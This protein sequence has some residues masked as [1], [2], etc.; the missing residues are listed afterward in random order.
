MYTSPSFSLEDILGKGYI[1]SLAGANEALGFMSADEALNIAREKI[2]FYPAE[3][4]KKNDE[5]LGKVGTS[6]IPAFENDNDGAATAAFAK[7]LSKASAPVTGMGCFRV[8]EDGRLYLIGKSEHYHAPLGHRFDGYKLIDK[9]RA[10]GVLNATHNNTR[11]YITRLCEKR[12]VQSVNGI[13]WDDDAAAE[14]VIS[15]TEHKVLNRVINLETGSL[16]VEA[17]IKMMLARFYKLSPEFP[18]PKYFGKTPVFFVMQDNKGGREAN[19]HGTTVV[20][21]TFRGLWPEFAE[22]E[23]EAGIYKVVPVAINDLDDF[24][25]KIEEYNSGNYKT[26]GFLHEIILM[27]YGGIKLTEE[28]LQGAYDLCEQYDT[29]TLVDEI[30]SCMWY[31][32]FFQFRLYGLKPDFVIIGKGFPG[33]E[34][35]ASK[36]IATAE[37]DTLNQFGALVTNGQEELASLAYLITMSYMR[38]VGGEV[39]AIGERFEAGLKAIAAKHPKTIVK[40]EGMQ[41]LA[42]LHFA[43]ASRAAD[44]AKDMKKHC[45]DAS[46]QTYK[47]NCPPALL[48]KPPVISTEATIDHILAVIEKIIV[49]KEA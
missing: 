9:A 48:L 8:G 10:L 35:P 30:Q 32:G 46:A 12:L 15:S 40:A 31:R 49:E 6:V 29:P 14:K 43:D 18:E 33:G 22:K 37:Y 5:L 42:A 28:F 19:Y 16:S 13:D 39:E 44:F 47:P 20:A 3:K 34:Y 7:A 4:Q 25:A 26:A 45:I 21:Q 41:L 36:I 11:G 2:D 38:A 1:E 24:R 17:G 27:N 23:E